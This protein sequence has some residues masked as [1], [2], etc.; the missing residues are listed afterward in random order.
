MYLHNHIA[1]HDITLWA[2][3]ATPEV[4]KSQHHRNTLYM[5]DA[6][7]VFKPVVQDLDDDFV[8][9]RCLGR[10]ENFR[11]FEVF[12]MNKIK[13]KG[14]QAVLQNYFLNRGEIADKMM[15]HVYM[16]M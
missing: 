15:S 4:L 5:R 16:G 9:K 2:L 12:F 7:K 8:F 14:Y 1:H 13:E 3:G 6:M 11:N 10:E